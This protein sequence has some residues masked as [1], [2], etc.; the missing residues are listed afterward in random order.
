MRNETTADIHLACVT[1]LVLPGVH[2]RHGA[3]VAAGG[4]M[5]AGGQA[6]IREGGGSVSK[7]R[8]IPKLNKPFHSRITGHG[9]ERIDQLLANPWNWKIHTE[10]QQQA[11]AGSID[12]IGYVRSI[13]VNTVTGHIV[14]G[15]DRL[16]ILGRSD[17][18]EVDTEYVE[19]TEDEEKRALLLLDPIAAMSATDKEKLDEL[20][21]SVQSDD[22]RVQAMLADLAAKEGLAYGE[23]PPAPAE[24][25]IDR[26][27]ELR[28]KWQTQDG[29]TWRLSD[30]L[31]YVGDAKQADIVCDFAIF[32]PPWDWKLSEQT[33]ILSWANW[34][35]ACVM[36]LSE[37]FG[38]AERDDYIS[39]LV[40]DQFTGMNISN[41]SRYLSHRSLIMMLWFGERERFYKADALKILHANNIAESY[42][43][44]IPQYIPLVRKYGSGKAELHSDT[45]PLPLCDFLITLYSQPGEMVGDPFAGSGSFLISAAR[46][47]RKYHGSE[48]DPAVCAVILER[49]FKTLGVAPVLETAS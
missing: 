11:L 30:N 13:T 39:F 41:A 35:N 49:Y 3:P 26:A 36:G 2:P 40:W 20:L 42:N 37:C 32:D 23:E 14:D 46:L 27:G 48:I 16:L 12:D 22:E 43:A 19:L 47:G 33:E 38:L 17:V 29:Q 25:E 4:G 5:A 18:E 10:A 21:H 7:N 28:E 44:D 31:L 34:K 8:K 1:G 24:P 9:K 6:G 45:K 15:M